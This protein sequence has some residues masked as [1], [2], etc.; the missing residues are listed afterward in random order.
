MIINNDGW[1]I[2]EQAGRDIRNWLYQNTSHYIVY[3]F[4]YIVTRCNFTVFLIHVFLS[5]LTSGIVTG[6]MKMR[7]LDP[8]LDDV[9]YL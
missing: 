9:V 7:L 1:C 3:C 5:F 6:W 2:S 8:V 4:I